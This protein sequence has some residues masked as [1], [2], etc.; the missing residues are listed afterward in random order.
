MHGLTPFCLL[1]HKALHGQKYARKSLPRPC[2]PRDPAG[3]ID[4]MDF[5]FV[6]LA[7]VIRLPVEAQVRAGEILTREQ[8]R[9]PV[10]LGVAVT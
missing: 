7:Q 6:P 9:E 5:S 10:A 3:V 2:R 4:L 1:Q 8:L